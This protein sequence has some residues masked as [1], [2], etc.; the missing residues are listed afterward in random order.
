MEVSRFL[1]KG[2]EV[3]IWKR[4]CFWFY[5][6]RM[7]FTDRFRCEEEGLSLSTFI[8]TYTINVSV[9]HY[10]DCLCFSF[11]NQVRSA[12]LIAGL[13]KR[14]THGG[15]L[16]LLNRHVTWL[17]YWPV[18][19]IGYWLQ[20]RD[21]YAVRWYGFSPVWMFVTEMMKH[22]IHSHWWETIPFS[23]GSSGFM[24]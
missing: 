3:E 24:I 19:S 21:L 8:V 16:V 10:T 1:I 14:Q 12:L 17:A 2:D 7:S 23:S 15:T 13:E 22:V 20:P 11:P 9:H 18:V 6:T 4:N 5:L